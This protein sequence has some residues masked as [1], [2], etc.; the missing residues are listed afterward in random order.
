MSGHLAFQFAVALGIGLLVG[1]ERERRKGHGPSRAAA[2]IRTFTIVSL[3]GALGMNLGGG[4]LLA[5]M[6]LALGLLL[7]VGYQRSR[8]HDPGLTTEVALLL[9]LLLGAL[10]LRDPA[11]ASGLGVTLAVLLAARERLHRFVRRVLSQE[12]LA[13]ALILAAGALVVLPLLPDTYLGPFD[14]INLRTIWK[15]ALLVMVV[16]AA[17]YVALRTFGPR[18]G[19]PLA[20]FISGFISGTVTISTMGEL[21]AREPTLMGPAVTG[22]V[23]SSV[24][25]LILMAAVLAAVSPDTLKALALPLACGSGA[26]LAYGIPFLFQTVRNTTPLTS[27]LGDP[28][29]L[30]TV[31]LLAFALAVTL[32]LAATLNAWLGANGVLAAALVAGLADTHAAAASVASLVAAGKFDATQAAVPV[33]AALSA[34]TLS[35]AVFAWVS[36][37]RH[38]ALQVIPGLLLMVCAAWG[39]QLLWPNF[40]W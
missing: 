8:E 19:L 15:F 6:V 39:G 9:T 36:G 38:F 32:I 20:G 4:L 11:L 12:E 33:L 5:L 10:C 35:K 31:L 16:G 26:A 23:L 22:A 2:G 34:N 13:D 37:G 40:G 14:A 21:S 7:A 18:F 3:L 25:T 24:S 27:T 17:G 29:R 30:K 28:F 1:V